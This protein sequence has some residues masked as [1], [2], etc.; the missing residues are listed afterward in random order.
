MHL[1]TFYFIDPNSSK[2]FTL[3][4]ILSNYSFLYPL[5]YPHLNLNILIFWSANLISGKLFRSSS[6]SCTN[7]VVISGSLLK[8]L[9]NQTMAQ[10]DVSP[11]SLLT[12]HTFVRMGKKYSRSFLVPIRPNK[13][14]TP[15]IFMNSPTD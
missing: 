13:L 15:N 11:P 3:Q 4:Y 6:S 9:R 7:H 14:W 1:A 2:T 8:I 12:S 5:F 10:R